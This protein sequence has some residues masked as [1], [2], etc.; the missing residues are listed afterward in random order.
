M[1]GWLVA[2]NGGGTCR[3]PRNTQCKSYVTR[4]CSF[5]GP[6]LPPALSSHLAGEEYLAYNVRRWGGDGWCHDLRRSGRPDGALFSSWKWWP[7]SARGH[8]LLLLA[9]ER[10]LGRQ[11]KELLLH[12]T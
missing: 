8:Q 11:C 12:K 4:A 10:G 3:L 5:Q 6:P 1:E 7:A 9:Q 2:R